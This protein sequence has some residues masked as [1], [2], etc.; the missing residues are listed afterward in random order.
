[1]MIVGTGPGDEARLANTAWNRGCAAIL[2]AA[3][4]TRIVGLVALDVAHHP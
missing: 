4:D 3:I 2:V 1:M